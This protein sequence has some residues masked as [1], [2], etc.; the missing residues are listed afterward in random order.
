MKWFVA[1]GV[2]VSLSVVL[3]PLLVLLMLASCLALAAVSA[4]L[5]LLSAAVLTASRIGPHVIR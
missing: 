1:A 5:A 4:L 3:G 2:I